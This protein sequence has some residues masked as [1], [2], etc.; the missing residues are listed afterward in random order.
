MIPDLSSIPEVD[1]EELAKEVL[2]ALVAH[3]DTTTEA[4]IESYLRI[5]GMTLRA[6]HPRM[7][8]VQMRFLDSYATSFYREQAV[9]ILV[10]SGIG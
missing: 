5:K 1:G 6:A 2:S 8:V 10:E 7:I 9:R 3:P 4:A